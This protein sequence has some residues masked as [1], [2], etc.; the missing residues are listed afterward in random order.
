MAE[1]RTAS[2]VIPTYDRADLVERSLASVARSD[3][4]VEDLE[5]IVVDDGSSDDTFATVRPFGGALNLKY[6]FQPDRG[7]R[8]ARARNLGIS[9]AEN[10]VVIFIDSGIAVPSWHV[11]AH[12]AAHGSATNSTVIGNILGFD[13][14][15]DNTEMLT[16]ELV[17]RTIDEVVDS[18]EGREELADP[19]WPA[20]NQ[21]GGDLMG[22]PAPWALGWSA[23][24]S[25]HRSLLDQGIR[26]D[27]NYRSWGGEDQDFSLALYQAGSRFT[28][29]RAATVVHIPHPKSES[30]NDD[31]A[32]RNKTYL[33]QKYRLPE[34]ELLI[35][36]RA[37]QL[38]Q[39]LAEQR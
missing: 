25:V 14:N 4:A 33:H 7:H 2:I 1:A 10:D 26:F 20:W 28:L 29:S 36:M 11:S 15:D 22:L 39:V 32:V 37:V 35:G 27:E 38:N 17:G 31:S 3:V 21:C 18:W 8:A 24:L 16:A 19:R 9:L 13:Y 34:T 5:V 30:S 23:N 6:V 12:L